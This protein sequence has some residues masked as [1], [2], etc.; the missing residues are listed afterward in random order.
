MVNAVEFIKV[1]SKLTEVDIA[2]TK[3]TSQDYILINLQQT[4]VNS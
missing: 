1:N 2:L 4:I 3:Q